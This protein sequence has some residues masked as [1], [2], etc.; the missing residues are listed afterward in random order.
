ML[1]QLT[2]TV[3][4]SVSKA[5]LPDVVISLRDIVKGEIKATQTTDAAGKT[6]FSVEEGVWN[7]SVFKGGYQ[8]QISSVYLTYPAAGYKIELITQTSTTQPPGLPPPE[9]PQLPGTPGA[10]LPLPSGTQNIGTYGNRC[11][12]LRNPTF[13]QSFF[14][15]WDRYTGQQAPYT[16]DLSYAR[17][18]AAADSN[19]YLSAPP[20]PA[21]WQTGITQKIAAGF[22]SL[23][24]YLTDGLKSAAGN[25]KLDILDLE[26]R[27]KAWIQTNIISKLD[28]LATGI[29][30]LTGKIQAEAA[31]RLK[32]LTDLETNL[33]TWISSNILELLLLKLMEK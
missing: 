9:P 20:T 18:R 33:K 10:A 31:A 21:D 32:A 22:D 6:I 25:W 1:S 27:L 14:T 4:D 7:Y 13:A 8:G 11:D 2:L 5:P 28:G 24:K 15:H 12:L 23:G 17:S 16:S 3:V 26:A 30:D 29:T 19:C